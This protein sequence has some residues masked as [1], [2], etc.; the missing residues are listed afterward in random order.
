M[1]DLSSTSRRL[2]RKECI[3]SNFRKVYKTRDIIALLRTT[4]F[5][6]TRTA[7]KHLVWKHT[8]GIT[9]VLGDTSRTELSDGV[10]HK[11]HKQIKMVQ[12]GIGPDGMKLN[13]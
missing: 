2:W 12:R 13:S 8:T 6:E 10:V 4:G 1:L 5:V 7:G 11:I 3:V 9:V